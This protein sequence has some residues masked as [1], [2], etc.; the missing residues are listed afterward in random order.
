MSRP[1]KSLPWTLTCRCCS[2][3]LSFPGPKHAGASSLPFT[4][5]RGSHSLIALAIPASITM[6]FFFLVMSHFYLA[7]PTPL[8]SPISLWSGDFFRL[9]LSSYATPVSSSLPVFVPLTPHPSLSYQCHT[10]FLLYFPLYFSRPLSPLLYTLELS[11]ADRI[12]PN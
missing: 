5:P 11:W 4:F 10:Y 2:L 9:S 7:T 8:F 1:R 6:R 12:L 3:P